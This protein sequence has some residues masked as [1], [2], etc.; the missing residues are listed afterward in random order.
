MTP[1][2]AILN[3]FTASLCDNK[4]FSGEVDESEAI[5]GRIPGWS[6]AI[7]Y[8]FFRALLTSAIRPPRILI[9]GVYHGLDLALIELAGTRTAKYAQKSYETLVGIDLFSDQ[10]CADWTDKQRERK[11]WKAAHGVTPPSI[12]SARKNAPGA[13]VFAS[14][15]AA[16]IEKNGALFDFLFLDTSHDLI[17]V[18]REIRAMRSSG[19]RG[20]IAG[21][22]YYHLPG[23]GVR[24]AVEELIP[25]HV[26]LF[27]RIWLAQIP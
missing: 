3:E 7:H 20:V 11:T 6:N 23:W 24:S 18:R 21:D 1:V 5:V 17:T 22:D 8:L 25:D 16:F 9:C 26:V 4:R 14:D 27:N 10:P 12:E 15:S 19:F 2:S 13:E